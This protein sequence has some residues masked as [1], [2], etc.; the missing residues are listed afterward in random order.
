MCLL[1]IIQQL[2]RVFSAYHPYQLISSLLWVIDYIL[3]LL[4]LSEIIS[5]MSNDLYVHAFSLL[6]PR[7]NKQVEHTSKIMFCDLDMVF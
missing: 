3:P 2:M 6:F 5:G 4:S 1:L 7:R